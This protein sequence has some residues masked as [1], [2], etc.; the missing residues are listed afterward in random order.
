MQQYESFAADAG[1]HPAELGLAWLLHQPV[2]SSV[3]VGPRTAAQLT[4]AAAAAEVAL[5]EEQLAGLDTIW[6]G[7]GGQAPEAYAW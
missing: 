2:V 5:S 7:P 1:V 6:P 3:V 4:S